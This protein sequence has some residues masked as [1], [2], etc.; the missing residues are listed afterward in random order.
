MEYKII[1]SKFYYLVPF[2]IPKSI[3]NL[4]IMF[5]IKE[6][7]PLKNF[8]PAIPALCQQFICFSFDIYAFKTSKR[9]KSEKF[10]SHISHCVVKFFVNY[11]VCLRVVR[12][13]FDR[14]TQL[15]PQPDLPVWSTLYWF[16]Q[17][18]DSFYRL[19]TM[20]KI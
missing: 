13:F 14:I 11:P 17:F 8:P 18:G 20:I 19:S 6:K 7:H 12:F 2:T 3:A 9:K 1:F 16:Y 5:F 10:N 4:R 15:S